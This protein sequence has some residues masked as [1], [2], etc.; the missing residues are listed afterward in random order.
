[1]TAKEIRTAHVRASNFFGGPEKQILGHAER[2]FRTPGLGIRPAVLSFDEKGRETELVSRARGAGVEARSIPCVTAYD[3]VQV[4]RLRKALIG[5]AAD[6]VC[7]HDYRSSLLCRLAL[8]GSDVS[9]VVFWRGVTRE[10]AKVRL[11]HRMERRLLGS[12][13][14]VVVVSEEQRA[15]LIRE[16]IPAGRVTLVP[17]AVDLPNAADLPYVADAAN[18]G[19]AVGV[20]GAADAA[21]TVDR[22]HRPRRKRL[23]AAVGE[24]TARTVLATASRLSPEKG[25]SHLLDA[26]PEIMKRDSDVT[27]LV[28]GDG[29][30]EGRLRAQAARLGCAERVI[31]AGLVPDF[32][33]L[34]GE[35]DVFVLPSLSEGLP[36]ALLEAMAAARP[37]VAAG[38]GGVKDLVRNEENGL[39]VPPADGGALAAA[40]LRL[41][42]DSGLALRL[43]RSAR[44]TVEASHSFARQC[45]LLEKM[46]RGVCRRG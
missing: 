16:G 31:F 20:T 15:F 45:E 14:H 4:L 21:G 32:A 36:N 13:S 43:G 34:V 6:V 37:V 35:V 30:L 12:V 38:V 28:F 17:N 27:L 24:M 41:A 46:Y 11:F 7:T 22:G 39:L 23:E 33:S 26:M 2:L 42:S 5:W 3:P 29:P 1:M 9:Q 25:L 10:N 44:A 18:A 8:G 40:I 19:G